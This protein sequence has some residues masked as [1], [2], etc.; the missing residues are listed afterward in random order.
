MIIDCIRPWLFTKS[1]A[2][3]FYLRALT[4]LVGGSILQTE[5]LVITVELIEKTSKGHSIL[6]L[7]GWRLAEWGKKQNWLIF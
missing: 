7:S 1:L 5:T 3:N 4:L 6:N 2:G